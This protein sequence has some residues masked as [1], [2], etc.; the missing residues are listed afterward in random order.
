MA[1]KELPSL[2]GAE[3]RLLFKV[4]NHLGE[5]AFWDSDGGRLLWVDILERRLFVQKATGYQCFGLPVMPSVIWKVVNDCVYLGT[6]EGVGEIS[7][8]TG[9]YRTVVPIEAERADT[10]SNDGGAAPDGS[11]WLGTM[12]REPKSKK[13]SIYR[14]SPDLS[15][16]HVDGR[17]GIPN[18]FLFPPK[19]NYALIGDTFDRS[20]YWY[21]LNCG[22]PRRV[23]AWLAKSDATT[24]DP[25]GSVLVD[26]VAVVNAEWDGGRLVAYDLNGCEYDS[27]PLPVSRP[28][29][30][31]LGGADGRTL[32]VTSA[33]EGLSGEAHAR[34]PDAGSI[35]AVH[36]ESK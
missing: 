29:S 15:V 9:V 18:T 33:R 24:G 11:F 28:T 17:A 3:V 2:S 13:G 20:I 31:A 16:E 14:I 12:L 10:R 22:Q 1:N 19:G 32:F 36:L 30:C 5:G 21:D 26:G 7:L 4:D 23:G 8:T 27:L 34:E 6:D 35:F 25:D